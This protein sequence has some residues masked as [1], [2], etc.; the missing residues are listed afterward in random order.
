MKWKWHPQ[1]LSISQHWLS[2]AFSLLFFFIEQLTIKLCFCAIHSPSIHGKLC[3]GR[4]S[5]EFFLSLLV[6]S[7]FSQINKLSRLFFSPPPHTLKCAWIFRHTK[8]SLNINFSLNC[9]LNFH[10][11]SRVWAIACELL[12]HRH[13]SWQLI[14][15]RVAGKSFFSL[16]FFQLLLSSSSTF[17]I[18]IIAFSQQ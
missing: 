5:F 7:S 14:F 13:P 8:S 4:K 1:P 18:V 11:S 12:S 3:Q 17:I 6:Y 9:S 2:G 15:P 10:P 16:I